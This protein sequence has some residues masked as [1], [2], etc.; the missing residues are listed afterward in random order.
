M[1][2]PGILLEA[3]RKALAKE[4]EIQEFIGR[5]NIAL[6][7]K[8]LQR[9]PQRTVA[10][11]VVPPDAPAGLGERVRRQARVAA[12]LVHANIV[13]IYEVGQAAGADF[14]TMKYVDGCS[15]DWVIAKH[16]ALPVP[17]ALTVLRAVVGGLAY[18]HDRRVIH[19]DVMGANVFVDR[20]GGVALADTG[21]ARAIQE[22]GTAAPVIGFPLFM[23]PEQCVGRQVGPQADQYAI[24]VLT[25]QMLTGRPPF[26]ADTAQALLELHVAAPP[27]EIGMA[28][29]DVPQE[30]VDVVRRAL[31]KTPAE[32][33]PTTRDMLRAVEAVPLSPGEQ[34]VAVKQLQELARRAPLPTLLTGSAP[35]MR[36]APAPQPPPPAPKPAPAPPPPP[37]PRV[38]APQ[39]PIPAPQPPIPA[40]PPPKPAPAPAPPPPKPAP[41]PPPPPKPAPAPAPP[42]P[43]PP[44]PAP[45]P[46]PPKPAPAPPPPPPPPVVEPVVP[47]L[48]ELELEPALP[49]PA[50]PE[51]EPEPAL[52]ELELMP[53][54]PEPAQPPAARVS[55]PQPPPEPARPP[56]PRVSAPQPQREPVRPPA[57]SGPAV[58]QEPPSEPPRARRKIP[59]VAIVGGVALLA[60]AAVVAVVTMGK[61]EGTAG[62]A[63]A[64]A[65]SARAAVPAVP[66]APAA[67]PDSAAPSA[68]AAEEVGYVRIRGD[69]PEDAI[70]WLD[71]RRMPGKV[72]QAS[73]GG[74]GLE[75]ETGEFEPWET[76]ITVRTGDTLRVNVELMLK[77]PTDS[78]L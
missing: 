78:L 19:R 6:V 13:P 52:P 42:P 64:P 32:R 36:A 25:F 37:A 17:L 1:T 21:I 3:L 39:P 27:P 26:E 50:R 58:I 44:K 9:E 69:L 46:P 8:A 73:P 10:L 63:A 18:A 56:A 33:Y 12:N 68:P 2:D 4:Y 57:R 62:P 59:I 76:R 72:F 35:P 51:P 23:S 31:S 7:Y 14:Y 28:R 67:R 29:A 61:R 20:E 30:F 71:G 74:H 47:A 22:Q 65:D 49:E 38:S 24:G 16:G 66:I 75:I 15:L 41:A 45:A 55:A 40:P 48:L 53:V 70:I 77:T 5:G 54:L 43:P 60:V 34:S 11:K